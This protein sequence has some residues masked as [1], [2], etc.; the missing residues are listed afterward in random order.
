MRK[1]T[2][3]WPGVDVREI[4]ASDFKAVGVDDQG[5]VVFDT[6][7]SGGDTQ[8]VSDDAAKWLVENDTFKYADE[9]KAEEV[10]A[11]EEKKAEKG[12]ARS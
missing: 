1:V 4:N 11:T 8:E 5:K 7:V 10:P 3:F 2:F 12:S 9:E 6:R